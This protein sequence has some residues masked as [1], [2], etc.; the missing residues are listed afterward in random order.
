MVTN[1][2]RIKKTC[3]VCRDKGKE[4]NRRH[5]ESREKKVLEAAKTLSS[6]KAPS[7]TPSTPRD[8]VKKRGIAEDTD[9]Y[10]HSEIFY[11]TRLGLTSIS[12]V[13]E[14]LLQERADDETAFYFRKALTEAHASD[15]SVTTY[16]DLMPNSEVRYS[17]DSARKKKKN[18]KDSDSESS[19]QTTTT[20]SK[21]SKDTVRIEVKKRKHF[22]W[23][24]EAFLNIANL[25]SKIADIMF[26]APFIS[27]FIMICFYLYFFSGDS[28]RIFAK[29]FLL[30]CARGTFKA[31]QG[32]K[33]IDIS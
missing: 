30:G 27:L 9:H 6:Q 11:L 18:D 32:N 17:N 24:H 26:D 19:F 33:D 20:D 22:K 5:K 12:Q 10:E 23:L 13:T 4:K 8:S 16:A 31:I 29:E 21:S 25:I 7:L 28:V 2:N 15:E 1:T 14:E 3:R